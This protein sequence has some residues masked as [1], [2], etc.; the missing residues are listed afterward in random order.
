ML[1]KTSGVHG[2]QATD[3]FQNGQGALGID[4]EVFQRILQAGGHGNLSGE[5]NHSAGLRDGGFD[6]Y[7]IAQVAGTVCTGCHGGPR[8]SSGSAPHPAG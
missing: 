3:R 4:G 6:R 1:A 5:V 7:G 2:R 8:A